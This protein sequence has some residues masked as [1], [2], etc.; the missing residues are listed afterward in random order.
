MKLSIIVPV[1]NVIG[2]LASCIDSVDQAI[3]QADCS[4]EAELVLVDDGSSD[5]SAGLC[6]E[7]ARK[8]AWVRVCHRPHRGV[9]A[10]RNFALGEV[11]GEY[12]AW[13]DPD[14]LVDV[15]YFR[16]ILK[17]L[18]GSPDAVV[19]DYSTLPGGP[20]CYRDRSGI[21]PLEDFWRD[22]VRDDRLKGFLW[23]KILRRELVP[24][25]AFDESCVVMED[26]EAM[27]R[28]FRKVKTIVYVHAPIYVYRYRS[29]SAVDRQIPDRIMA[30]FR[31]ALKRLE[32]VEPQYHADAVSCAM[33][34]AYHYC[35]MAAKFPASGW[36]EGG[37]LAECRRYVRSHLKEG[38]FDPRNGKFRKL[39]FVLVALGLMKLAV[40]LRR[41]LPGGRKS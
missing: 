33:Y 31:L 32:E 10:A 26:F 12:L 40:V 36:A 19:F 6:D 5:G 29:G 7:L 20:R 37:R 18:Q 34:H 1:Y 28:L 24:V 25:P 14:D 3:R 2:F 38:L 22:L 39:Q 21:V 4:E 15:D 13:I 41:C 35:H 9:A 27:G 23:N 11:V 17:A 16:A 30:M 8:H